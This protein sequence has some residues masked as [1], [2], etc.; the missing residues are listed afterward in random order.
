M[1]GKMALRYSNLSG[2]PVCF[3]FA[4]VTRV[5]G[6]REIAYQGSLSAVLVPTESDRG[7]HRLGLIFDDRN[8][9]IVDCLHSE[10]EVN[11]FRA[12]C[13]A[14]GIPVTERERSIMTPCPPPKNQ[15]QV[16]SWS[17]KL[18]TDLRPS[19]DEAR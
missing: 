3:E 5:D 1:E 8:T 14:N 12:T 6:V 10:E 13:E 9:L 16:A 4:D 11:A 15:I 2:G 7:C 19:G 17:A 18:F